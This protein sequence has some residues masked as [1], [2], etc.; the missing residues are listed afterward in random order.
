MVPLSLLFS[1][2]NSL[3]SVSSLSCDRCSHSIT[4]FV[5]LCQA[6]SVSPYLSNPGKPGT[7]HSTPHVSHQAWVGWKDHPPWPA[8]S[9]LHSTAQDASGLLGQLGGQPKPQCPSQFY[10]ISKL[11]PSSRS[12][13]KRLNSI[14]PDISSLSTPLGLCATDHNPSN[15]AVQLVQSTSLSIY[16]VHTIS[17]S[18][19]FTE[20][21]L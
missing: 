9:P 11:C 14:G 4:I 6:H 21:N 3:K 5:A 19:S 15:P 18:W 7:G 16:A 10:I 20:V 12:L 13:M 8:A 17:L 1:R 2:L